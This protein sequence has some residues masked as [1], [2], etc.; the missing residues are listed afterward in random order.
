MPPKRKNRVIVDRE[1]SKRQ[2]KLE[3]DVSLDSEVSESNE[4]LQTDISEYERI[5]LE[6]IKRNEMFLSDLGV[7]SV[8][9]S[10]QLVAPVKKAKQRKSIGAVK[11]IQLPTRRSSRVTVEKLSSEIKALKEEGKTEEAVKKQEELDVMT[12]KQKE[13]AYVP[14]FVVSPEETQARLPSEPL[15]LSSIK[16]LIEDED[17]VEQL[18]KDLMKELSSSKMTKTKSTV[19]KEKSENSIVATYSKLRLVEADVVKM[20][21]ARITAVA[22]APS[23]EHIVAVAGDKYGNLGIWNASKPEDSY[24]V[25]NYRPHVSN[26][27]HFH[28]TEEDVNKLFSVSYDGTIRAL[29]L[30]KEAFTLAFEAPEG[31]SE[32]YYSDATF[33]YDKSNAAIVSKSDGFVSLID[34]RSSRT[35]Y[36]WNFEAHDCKINGVQQH[37]TNSNLLI[38]AAA[39]NGGIAVHDI[40]SASKKWKPLHFFAEHTKSINGAYVS[41]DG[42]Y[43][44]SVS[45][46]DTIRAWK[47]FT[48]TGKMI[49]HTLRHNN[50]TGRWLSTFRPSFDPKRD[51][52]F[53][54]G[55]M[56]QPRRIELFTV[57]ETSD[58]KLGIDLTWNLQGEWLAS[59]NSRNCFHA[60]LDMVLGS[61]SSG[62]VHLFR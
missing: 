61:N 14:E 25:Y 47:N 34:F 44:I 19:K 6:N 36:Q 22:L 41:P 7:A 60:K 13:G 16:N 26:I 49:S 15:A 28:F 50:F 38:T 45:L 57:Q 51:H 39:R 21:A 58:S 42:E 59:V 27:I 1:S 35:S 23:I 24:R 56:L 10:L 2:K 20:T 3:E 9:T 17:D 12:A 18:V 40:R 48:G 37:P 32:L 46:D 31:L 33:L 11:E 54:C 30:Q 62:K 4:I 43:L 5:R 55:S 53:V 29:D 52:T 8:R